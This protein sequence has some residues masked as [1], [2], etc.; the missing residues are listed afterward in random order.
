MAVLIP[1]LRWSQ[2]LVVLLA[3]TGSFTYHTLKARSSRLNSGLGELRENTHHV[4]NRLKGKGSSRLLRYA[5][6]QYYYLATL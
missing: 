2:V 6:S 5:E 4:P 1:F 3:G